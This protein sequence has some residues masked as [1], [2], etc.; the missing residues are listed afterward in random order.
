MRIFG[1]K[2]VSDKEVADFFK[3]GIKHIK[4]KELEEEEDEEEAAKVLD[5]EEVE[6]PVLSELADEADE[7]DE[8]ESEYDKEII[9]PYPTFGKDIKWLHTAE[10]ADWKQTVDFWVDVDKKFVHLKYK[11]VSWKAVS[12]LMGNLWVLVKKDDMWYG[13]TCEWLKKNQKVKEKK[14]VNGDH[15]KR[16]PLDKW[17][18]GLG[19]EIGF[20]ISGLARDA[21]RNVKERSNVV[22]VKWR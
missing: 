3:R 9:C 8:D 11:D 6:D 4:D 19:E 7:D 14:C 12:G 15:I 2:S 21:K 18:P 22:W 10:V 5:A 16:K 1:N 13:G 20:F 17:V